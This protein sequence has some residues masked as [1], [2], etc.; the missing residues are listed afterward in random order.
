M[1]QYLEDAKL[2]DL[3][4]KYSQFVQFPVLMKETVTKK[5]EQLMSDEE[6]AE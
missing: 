4:N 5:E 2:K 6:L 1:K 3:V